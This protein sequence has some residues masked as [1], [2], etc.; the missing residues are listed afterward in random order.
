M[1]VPEVELNNIKLQRLENY[2]THLVEC[3]TDHIIIL[4]LV[5]T[6][7]HNRGNSICMAATPA[8]YWSALGY[9]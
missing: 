3:Y 7:E 8:S 4:L 5:S 1:S 9:A 2:T 6:Q